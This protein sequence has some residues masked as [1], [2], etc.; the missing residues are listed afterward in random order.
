MCRLFNTVAI[1]LTYG[2]S[3]LP[4]LFIPVHAVFLQVPWLVLALNT[5]FASVLVTVPLLVPVPS[6]A[7]KLFYA[8]LNTLAFLVALGVLLT[9]DL[10]SPM[11]LATAVNTDPGE[12]LSLLNTVRVTAGLLALTWIAQLAGLCLSGPAPTVKFEGSLGRFGNL[13]FVLLALPGLAPDLSLSYPAALPGMA[14]KAWSYLTFRNIVP[15]S[16]VPSVQSL[17]GAPNELMV[18]VIGESSSADYWQLGGSTHPTSPLLVARQSQGELVYFSKHLSAS[19][20]TV[21]AVPNILTP[22]AELQTNAGSSPRPSIISLMAKAGRRTAWLATQSPQVAST[23]AADIRFREGNFSFL[24]LNN[25]DEGLLP[26]IDKWLRKYLAEPGFVV[27]HTQG[28][29]IPFELRYPL[30]FRKWPVAG[31]RFP[32]SQ[33]EGNYRNTILYTDHVLDRLMSRLEEENRPTILVYVA[34]H[35]ESVMRS[36][37]QVRTS[38]PIGPDV[39]HVPFIV[40]ANTSWRSAHPDRWAALQAKTETS[41]HHLNLGPTLMHLAGYQYDGAPKQRDLLAPEFTPWETVLVT[42]PALSVPIALPPLR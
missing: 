12:A 7:K 34:D 37:H 29:H 3:V 10:P 11:A 6:L 31:G 28:S 33:S 19:Q 1:V 20:V 38:A 16:S 32:N 40:W 27:M 18:L 22:F 8:A 26:D 35:G 25:L 14:A 42:A 36:G 30:A 17:G 41:T 5:L 23:E 15:Q 9:G 4:V 24:T 2:Y 13:L 39:L 21:L